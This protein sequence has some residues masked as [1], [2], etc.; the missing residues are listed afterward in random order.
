MSPRSQPSRPAPPD[1]R[2]R[3]AGALETA[4]LAVLLI[5]LTARPFVNEMPFRAGHHLPAPSRDEI[6]PPPPDELVRVG[7]AL[8]LLAATALWAVAGAVRGRFSVGG[9][10]LGLLAA[11][12]SALS[13]GSCFGAVD[14]RAAWIGWL[15]QA[16]L[17]AAAF[18]A[19]QLAGRGRRWGLVLVVLAALAGTMG[20][21]AIMQRWVEYPP[22]IAQFE[23][24]PD[25]QL[26][27]AGVTPDTPNAVRF[28]KRL[29]DPAA[30][31]YLFLSNPF[32]A[33]MLVLTLAAV[34]LAAEKISA[35]H[36]ARLYVAQ[37]HN[38]QQE[39]DALRRIYDAL[40]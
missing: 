30:Y 1:R 21:K 36:R 11:L 38:P 35:A 33:L 40:L 6:S 7:F 13:V 14:A 28:E 15:E 31:G 10:G 19:V 25:K 16:S 32:A 5:V 24:E 8:L 17:P 23:A 9:W 3:L 34:G 18:L 22:R 29:R 37:H 4:A 12:F 26:E 27:M 20:A 2:G 39:A